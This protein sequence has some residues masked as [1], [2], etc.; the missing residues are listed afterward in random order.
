MPR[1][2]K[3]VQLHL[4]E[5]NPNRISKEKL[6][7]RKEA[8][9]SMTFKSDNLKAPT[10]LDKEA[11]KIFN[12]LIKEFIAAGILVNVDVHGLALYCDAYSDYIRYTNTIA[13]Q[14]DQIEQTNK[15]GATNM[16]P[17]PLLTKK[18]QAFDQMNK[19]AGDFGLSPVAR[20]RL[21]VNLQKD[22]DDGNPFSDR[23]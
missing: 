18:K 8:E 10:W 2:A 15:M 3:P 13:E 23:L 19:V 21:A 20:A 9:E 12:K 22:E 1:P 6:D 16:I 17:H 11:K 4:L 5:G 7:K 14:G